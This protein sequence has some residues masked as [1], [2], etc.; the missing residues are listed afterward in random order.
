MDFRFTEQ[1]EAFRKEVR[2][3]LKKE[4]PHRDRGAA[5]WRSEAGEAWELARQFT[6]KLGEKRWTAI[7]WP[8]E[9]GGL[10]TT[11]MEYLI[12]SEEAA[13]HRAPRVDTMGTG[14]V[15][16]TILVHGTEEQKKKWFLAISSG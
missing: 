8:E 6:K 1:E 15:G 4:L 11:G 3:F 13:Y 9:Y 12:F 10:G 2:D 7:W 14:I 16:P 5:M